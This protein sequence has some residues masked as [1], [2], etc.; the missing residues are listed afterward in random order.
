MLR[1]SRSALDGKLRDFDIVARYG[2]EEFVVLMP[3]RPR[4][5]GCV[6]ERLRI[7]RSTMP[8]TRRRVGRAFTVTVSIGVASRPADTPDDALKRADEALYDAKRSGRNRVVA[9]LESFAASP[10]DA[11]PPRAAAS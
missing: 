2:G 7:G 3:E 5:R 10:F 1:R 4:H 6:A 11:E 9:K 8:V